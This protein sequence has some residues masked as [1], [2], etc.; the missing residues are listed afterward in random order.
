MRIRVREI[1]AR[2]R[3]S[4]DGKALVGNFS[5]MMLLQIS[6]YVFP[7]LTIPYLARVIGVDGFGKIAFAA[8]VVV[9]FQAL[10]D[11]GFNYTAT[12]DVAQNRENPGK[13]SAIF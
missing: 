2:L 3:R 4:K 9:W 12:R 7:L 6:G 13:V 5:Y 1:N 10:T 11:W 8:A